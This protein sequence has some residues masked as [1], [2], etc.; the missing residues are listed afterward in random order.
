MLRTKFRLL[1]F[2]AVTSLSSGAFAN[3][4]EH[5][6]PQETEIVRQL[7]YAIRRDPTV[8]SLSKLP[9]ASDSIIVEPALLGRMA[10]CQPAQ[11]VK[12]RGQFIVFWNQVA[13]DNSCGKY[14]Y[15]AIVKVKAGRISRLTFGESDI[16]VTPGNKAVE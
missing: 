11:G 14:G 10:A 8:N 5:L 7:D 13:P 15:Y 6:T 3:D 9:W 2:V 1:R 4:T 16:I 12:D